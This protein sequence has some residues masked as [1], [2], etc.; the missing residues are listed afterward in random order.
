[1]VGNLLGHWLVVYPDEFLNLSFVQDVN[2]LVLGQDVSVDSL[3]HGIDL[4]SVIGYGNRTISITNE[5]LVL[6]SK[7]SQGRDRALFVQSVGLG[8][9]LLIQHIE[10]VDVLETE[11][12]FL[13]TNYHV[14]Q[15]NVDLF[16]HFSEIDGLDR[17]SQLL[18][19]MYIDLYRGY[20]NQ[21]V[22]VLVEFALKNLLLDLNSILDLL[23]GLDINGFQ[24]VVVENDYDFGLIDETQVQR[25]VQ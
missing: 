6:E 3:S 18:Y 9:F 5:D 19:I 23:V 1:M 21:L 8:Q 17:L 22:S 13:E 20:K 12:G 24:N 25:K 14:G 4:V 11:E 16:D 10:A 7:D 15:I 2:L